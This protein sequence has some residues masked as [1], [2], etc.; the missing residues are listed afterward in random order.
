MA[1]LDISAGFWSPH[2]K[3]MGCCKIKLL[4]VKTRPI[5]GRR[6]SSEASFI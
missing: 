2:F 4:Y 1:A 5:K 3:D 6:E